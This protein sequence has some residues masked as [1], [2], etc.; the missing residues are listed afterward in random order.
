MEMIFMTFDVDTL[1]WG[2]VPEPE[3]TD[4]YVDSWNRGT[5]YGSQPITNTAV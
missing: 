1:E 2:R 4:V 3:N 5:T